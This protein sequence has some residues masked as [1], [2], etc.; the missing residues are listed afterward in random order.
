MIGVE[1]IKDKTNKA[2]AVEEAKR[3]TLKAFKRG[4]AVTTT[5]TY[6]SVIRIAPSLT[7][8]EELAE[9]GFEIIED[10]LKKME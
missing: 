6:G 9:K 5:V 4:L 7:I 8:T 2:Q 3:L 10:V 1:L